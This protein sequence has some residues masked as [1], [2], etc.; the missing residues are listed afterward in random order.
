MFFIISK[1]DASPP[2]SQPQDCPATDELRIAAFERKM[3]NAINVK[4]IANSLKDFFLNL[5][6]MPLPR[7]SQN[8]EETRKFTVVVKFPAKTRFKEKYNQLSS[9]VYSKKP[10]DYLIQELNSQMLTHVSC[11][12]C[13]FKPPKEKNPL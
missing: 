13:P 2:K 5:H 10:M 11:L 12:S 8:K 4:H 7:N 1:R 3:K 6:I 9:S